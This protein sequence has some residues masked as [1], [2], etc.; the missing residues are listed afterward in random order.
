MTSLNRGEACGPASPWHSRVN[1]AIDGFRGE[2]RDEDEVSACT[3]TSS[4][5][6]L[7]VDGFDDGGD[8]DEKRGEAP[9]TSK[10]LIDTWLFKY[11]EAF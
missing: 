5:E 7:M 3:L 11:Q 9:D 2:K 10:L 4:M 6:G 1:S 8:D